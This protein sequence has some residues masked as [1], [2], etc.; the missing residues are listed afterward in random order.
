[1]IWS[2]R[3]DITHGRTHGPGVRTQASGRGAPVLPSEL[4]NAPASPL[5]VLIK[6]KNIYNIY[7]IQLVRIP[8][9]VFQRVKLATTGA[10]P[11]WGDMLVSIMHTKRHNAW[12]SKP[13]VV[14]NDCRSGLP[15][16]LCLF[17]P[18]TSGCRLCCVQCQM[19]SLLSKVCYY[20]Q[21]YFFGVVVPDHLL[22]PGNI[23]VSFSDWRNGSSNFWSAIYGITIHFPIPS[24]YGFNENIKERPFSF[25]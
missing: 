10:S 5:L 25:P 22:I 20:W 7:N 6:S 14:T 12:Y 8:A 3:F 18:G 17:S 23:A 21:G 24:C 19:R 2:I 9:D 15:A 13:L 1:M 11:S 16:V 4:T